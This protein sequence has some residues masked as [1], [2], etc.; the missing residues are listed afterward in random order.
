MFDISNKIANK[1]G[2]FANRSKI[3]IEKFI[4]NQQERKESQN[5]KKL[6]EQVKT[7]VIARLKQSLHDLNVINIGKEEQADQVRRPWDRDVKIVKKTTNLVHL[8]TDIIQIFDQSEISGKLLILGEPGSG[9]TTTLLELA[10]DL[11]SRAEANDEEAVPVLFNL[12]EWRKPQGMFFLSFDLLRFFFV[13][14]GSL[15]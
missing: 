15:V 9:K 13:E 2:I 3:V 4:F 1:I 11:V 7:E 5:R 10:R 14:K 8:E 6:I 12:S